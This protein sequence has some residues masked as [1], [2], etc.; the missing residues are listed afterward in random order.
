M[1]IGVLKEIKK[2]EYRVALL[3]VGAHILKEHNHEIYI[4]SNAGIGSGFADKH[5][6]VEGATILKTAE[7]V[8]EAANLILKVKE[9]LESEYSLITEK[10]TVFTYFHYAASKPLTTAMIG[11]NAITIAYETV[12]DENGSLPLLVPMSEVAGRMSIQ[13]GATFL[14][15][16]NGG[17]GVLLGGVPG[18]SPATVLILGAGVVGT[19]AAFIAAGMGADVYMLDINLERLRYLDDVMP[20]NVNLVMSNPHTIKQYLSLADLVVGGVLIPGAKA[21]K[22]I[23]R[24]MLGLM[25]KGSVIVDVAVDQGGCIETAKPTTHDDP[26][27]TIDGVVHYCVANMPGAVPF[28]S[29]IALNN[30]TFPFVLELAN[31]G[32]E[33]AIKV[34]KGLWHGVNTYKGSITYDKV[35]EAFELPYTPLEKLI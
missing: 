28:T 13:V 1:K 9:P 21:P 18:V 8:Y 15:K 12:Q 5:Y 6:A 34:H 19:N 31:K 20:K 23:T 4:Q 7:E 33:N 2:H 10:H 30:S 27:Y 11:S 29:T 25:K 32:V 3:P 24:D 35:A 26:T 14:E 17:R 22:L 16:M